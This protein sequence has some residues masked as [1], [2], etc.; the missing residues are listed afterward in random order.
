L[1]AGIGFWPD[2]AECSHFPDRQIDGGKQTIC[3]TQQRKG[4]RQLAVVMLGASEVLAARMMARHTVGFQFDCI[5]VHPTRMM[6][7]CLRR[8]PFNSMRPQFT[9]WENRIGVSDVV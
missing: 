7:Q 9:L 1:I 5:N 8:K 2:F 4:G 3:D 6:Q